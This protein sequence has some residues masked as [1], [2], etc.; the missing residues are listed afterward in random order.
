V[1][2]RFITLVHVNGA[3]P[4]ENATPSD[5]VDPPT[6]AESEWSINWAGAGV[7]FVLLVVGLVV[8]RSF[9][10]GGDEVASSGGDVAVETV[11]TTDAA[12][13]TS[14][15]AAAPTST[16]PTTAGTITTTTMTPERRVVIRGEMKPCRFSDRCLVASFTIEGFE[17]TSGQFVCVYPNSQSQFTFDDGGRDDACATA[18]EGDTIAIEVDGVRS[19]VISEA[20]LTGAP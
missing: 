10:D 15:D 17:Q 5:R 9:G 12:R 14:T 2:R 1:T 20:N 13:P 18:D 3:E 16:T 11:A 7:V 8:W 6:N 4:G 19:A